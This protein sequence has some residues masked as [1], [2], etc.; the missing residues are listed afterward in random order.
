MMNVMFV[1]DGKLVTA[2]LSDSIL[3]GV[4][5]DSLLTL[6]QDLGFKTEERPVAVAELEDAFKKGTITEAFGAGTA[7]VVAPIKTIHI[8]G[9][10][11]S[12]PQYDANKLQFKLKAGLE[13]IRLGVSTDVHGWNY[14]L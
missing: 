7:A 13:N 9:I 2:P 1:I 3:D 6:A 10:D 12:L 4:T 5:R 14:M 11:Y 8:N